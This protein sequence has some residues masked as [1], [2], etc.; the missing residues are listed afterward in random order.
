MTKTLVIVES[1]TKAKTIGKFLGS[2]YRVIASAGHVRDLPEK[3]LGVDIEKRFTPAYEILKGKHTVVNNLKAA[4][5]ETDN[6]LIATDPDREGE[7]IGWHLAVLLKV[8]PK[9]L[10]RVTFREITRS[11]VLSSIRNPRAIDMDLVDAQTARRILDR[12][13]GYKVSPVLWKKVKRGLSAGR[14]QSAA[15]HILC[16]REEEIAAFRKE[17]Y[18]S[19]TASVHDGK[20]NVFPAVYYGENGKKRRLNN[21][22]EAD[23]VIR[24]VS[25]APFHL[26]ALS[27]KEKKTHPAPPFKTSTLQ[28]EASR[29]LGFSAKK[30]MKIAQELFEGVDVGSGPTGLITY[31]RT[32]SARIAPE[33]V[34]S[35]RS[36]I[37]KTFGS[38]YLPEK[39]NYYKTGENAQ[40]G[41]E[42]IRP[43]DPARM[44]KAIERYL[45]ADQYK[46]YR[47]I[48][49]R[50]AACQ[51]AESV[52]EITNAV[53]VAN[54]IEFHA[55]GSVMKFD[56]FTR[57]YTEGKDTQDKKTHTLPRLTE[58]K[59]YEVSS[60]E[61]E[62]HFTE[63][64]A[65]YTEASLVKL[66]EEKGI[67]RPS[68]YATILSVLLDRGYSELV[69]KSL[70]PT[71]LGK[72][73]DGFMVRNFSDIV[74]AAFTAEMESRLDG[75]EH[76]ERS[77]L[78]VLDGFY[79]QFKESLRK[80]AD[81]EKQELPKEP[82]EQ[83]DT[84]CPKCGALMV[85]KKG[86]YG[87]YLACPNY[88]ACKS[89]QPVREE[90]GVACP[91]CGGMLL[92]K[93]GNKKT[94]YGCENYPECDFSVWDKPLKI[95][96]PKCG[97]LQVQ[98]VFRRKYYTSCT[99]PS[100]PSKKNR[101]KTE[102][103]DG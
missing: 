3:E 87:K 40:D 38:D 8:D 73:V 70:V 48:F 77:M 28:Q 23:S 86:R 62:Q 16:E 78:S 60:L 69:K 22:Q 20:G 72:A 71:L 59:D 9:S 10:C 4:A 46:L 84:P 94:F 51:M 100:C 76:R 68:T 75:I 57:A 31:H 7:A 13:V 30:T 12:L 41:H 58:G 82:E 103:K 5:K 37:E 49:A 27:S 56:G 18:W 14:V 91:K 61:K 80:A 92:K 15:L 67:G 85:Y 42:A 54:E 99:N 63:P 35:V 98:K 33:A 32:D 102:E 24:A 45:S 101:N 17:E 19:L 83:S 47:L 34:R 90:T 53:F 36:F 26:T 88:P 39:A 96:C 25:G 6:I 21:E 89:T 74:D 52:S 81:A 55:E 95:R 66:M 93:K 64:P 1:P 11:A 44:P 43:T 2:G 79:G 97:A 65:R 29:K 50:F